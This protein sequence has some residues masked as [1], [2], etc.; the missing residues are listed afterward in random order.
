[1]SPQMVER[2]WAAFLDTL[3]MVGASVAIAVALGVPLAV[4]L[5]LAAPGGLIR[6]PRMHRR[7]PR[8]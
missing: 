1:M 3:A 5:V 8:S 7:F 4:F 6:A 2:L